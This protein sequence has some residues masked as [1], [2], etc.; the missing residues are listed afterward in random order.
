MNSSHSKLERSAESIRSGSHCPS[1]HCR[2]SSDQSSLPVIAIEVL[3]L[4]SAPPAPLQMIWRNANRRHEGSHVLFVPASSR[5]TCSLV[6]IK[7]LLHSV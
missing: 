4:R 1:H 2:I 7:E 3:V 6:S 5:F